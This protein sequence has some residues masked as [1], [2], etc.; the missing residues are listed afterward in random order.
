M[1][2]LISTGWVEEVG[3]WHGVEIQDFCFGDRKSEFKNWYATTGDF[4]KMLLP[5]PGPQ[6]SHLQ[7]RVK[8]S[9]L[10]ALLLEFDGIKEGKALS[11]MTSTF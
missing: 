7:N 6:S 3:V 2:S 5:R 8:P 9:L 4:R 1:A 11:S 10:L